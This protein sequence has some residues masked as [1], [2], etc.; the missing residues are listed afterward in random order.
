[1]KN[2]PEYI[3]DQKDS[4]QCWQ[5]QNPDYWGKYREQHP[6]Y[7]ERNRILQMERDKKRRS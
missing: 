4:Q 1:M 2:D 5:E 6:K 3:T 7:V